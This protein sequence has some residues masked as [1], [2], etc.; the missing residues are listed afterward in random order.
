[1]RR[2][3][4][5]TAG[6]LR[7]VVIYNPPTRW[8][9]QQAKRDRT[10]HSS[11]A[12][13]RMNDKTAKG[14]L[15]LEIAAN[16]DPQD[17]LVT[18]TYRDEDLPSRRKKAYAD[19]RKYIAALRAVRNARGDDLKYIYVIEHKHGEGRFHFHIIMNRSRGADFEEI[20]S[21]WTHG[22]SIEIQ[23]LSKWASPGDPGYTALSEYLAKEGVVD[24]PLG[25]RMWTGSK[26]LKK[27]K[28]ETSWVS[29][30]TRIEPPKG[31]RV[32]EREEKTTEFGEY[33]YCEYIMPG[34]GSRTPTL[35][36]DHE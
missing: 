9:T 28:I 29:D 8:D 23:V 4:T 30:T 18:L 12:R 27:P 2:M 33:S 32:I 34:G 24:R 3:K 14:K 35:T 31:S 11:E 21:L 1:M 13:K 5:I 10:R 26:G 15:K 22:E 16:F 25:S 20:R 36:A 6:Q 19:V 7:R 17:Y